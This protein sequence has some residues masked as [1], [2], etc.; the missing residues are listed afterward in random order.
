VLT[1]DEANN[2]GPQ[3]SFPV[4]E[5]ILNH[6]GDNSLGVS[7]WAMDKAGAKLCGLDLK[8]K[9]VAETSYGSVAPSEQPKWVKRKRAY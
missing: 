7:L 1:T 2:V 8:A 6:R 9:L 4:P 5:G 3:T